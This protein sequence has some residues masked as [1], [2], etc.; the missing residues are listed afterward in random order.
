VIVVMVVVMVV[1][2]SVMSNVL[3]GRGGRDGRGRGLWMFVV[4]FISG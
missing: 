4:S 1:V 3:I 2:M